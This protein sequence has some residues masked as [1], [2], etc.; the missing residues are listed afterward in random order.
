MVS[1]AVLSPLYAG[2]VQFGKRRRRLVWVKPWILQRPVR[3]AYSQL[4]NYLLNIEEVSF[5]NL[6]QMG[7]AALEDVLA[8]VELVKIKAYDLQNTTRIDMFIDGVICR[9]AQRCVCA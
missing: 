5:R 6:G 2:A 4:V 1:S 3:S 9:S 8:R 7:L